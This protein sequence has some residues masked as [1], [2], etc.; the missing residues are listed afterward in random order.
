MIDNTPQP[1][2]STSDDYTSAR[3]TRTL[4]KEHALDYTKITGL[5]YTVTPSDGQR[6]QR[7][8]VTRAIPEE[9]LRSVLG[10]GAGASHV[11]D[12]EWI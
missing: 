7:E 3:R 11:D 1:V 5:I 10:A 9:K 6:R 2:S 12:G 4:R 8:T